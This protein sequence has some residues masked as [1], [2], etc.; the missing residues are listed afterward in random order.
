MQTDTNY[1]QKIKHMPVSPQNGASLQGT[2][3]LWVSTHRPRGPGGGWYRY[4]VNSGNLRTCKG[5]WLFMHHSYTSCSYCPVIPVPPSNSPQPESSDLCPLLLQIE[6][7]LFSNLWW[8]DKPVPE[9]SFNTQ[10][11]K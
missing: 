1:V 5:T 10:K 6:F 3:D 7:R 9:L 2:S 4:T 11:H 8:S